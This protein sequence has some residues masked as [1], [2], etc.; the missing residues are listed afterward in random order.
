MSLV[1]DILALQKLALHN[2][3][4]SGSLQ[5]RVRRTLLNHWEALHKEAARLIHAKCSVPSTG[6]LAQ[7]TL[8]LQQCV[9]AGPLLA[10]KGS[11]AYS[12]HLLSPGPLEAS[13]NEVELWRIGPNSKLMLSVCRST[14]G[15]QGT[16]TKSNRLVAQQSFAAYI[17]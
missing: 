3:V 15:V 11:T 2:R 8:E 9:D 14:S 1:D 13:Q 10:R 6:D 12:S 16:V 7:L 5:P 17:H 4:N